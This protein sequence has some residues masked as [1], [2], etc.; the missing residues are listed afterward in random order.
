ME[1]SVSRRLNILCITFKI[2]TFYLF[3][4]LYV[5]ISILLT[6]GKHLHDHIISV[7]VGVCVHETNL[8]PPSFCWSVCT[9]PGKSNSMYV[10][11]QCI[12][13]PLCKIFIYFFYIELFLRMHRGIFV[14]HF[15]SSCFIDS[16]FLTWFVLIHKTYYVFFCWSYLISFDL[17]F[18][19]LFIN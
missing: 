2:I 11:A 14:F 8:T 15:I 6:C 18:C 4:R 13:F 19:Y 17:S 16:I 1:T 10:C 3:A 7:K 12:D 5:R 9:N